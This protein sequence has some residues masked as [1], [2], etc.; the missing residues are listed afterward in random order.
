M[1]VIPALGWQEDQKLKDSLDYIARLVQTEL[2]AETLCI[3][4]RKKK[5]SQ[6]IQRL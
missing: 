3:N 4:K 1:F 6:H 2:Q 5:N